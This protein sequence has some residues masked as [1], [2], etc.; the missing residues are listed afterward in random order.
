MNTNRNRNV[1]DIVD[2]FEVYVK[3]GKFTDW[4]RNDKFLRFLLD[5][6]P[7]PSFQGRIRSKEA[8]NGHYHQPKDYSDQFLSEEQELELSQIQEMMNATSG[9]SYSQHNAEELSCADLKAR[10]LK[11]PPVYAPQL[12]VIGIMIYVL[13]LLDADFNS[14]TEA[15]EEFFQNWHSLIVCR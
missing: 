4:E 9:R 1:I 10:I 12:L 13:R 11:I 7:T 5:R 14:E 6:S 8:A 15:F 3:T 2:A